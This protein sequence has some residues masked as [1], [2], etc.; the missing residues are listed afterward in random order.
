MRKE[1]NEGNSSVAHNT[2]FEQKYD[3]FQRFI[4]Y[5]LINLEM[6]INQI[7]KHINTFQKFTMCDIVEDKE[8]IDIFKNLPLRDENELQLME[9]KLKNDL[10]YRQQM[11]KQLGRVT[12]KHLKMSCLRLMRAILSNEVAEKYSWYGAKKNKFSVNWR[13]VK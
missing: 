13:Y 3:N 1:S 12:S 7:E 9:T 6:K 10:W 8:N 11:I 5:K 2:N 4:V